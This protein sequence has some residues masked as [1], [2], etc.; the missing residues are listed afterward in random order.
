MDELRSTLRDVGLE[1]RRVRTVDNWVSV[2]AEDATH[3]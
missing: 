3:R 2:L 1:P